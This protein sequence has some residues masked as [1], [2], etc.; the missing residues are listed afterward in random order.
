MPPNDR[1]I[2]GLDSQLEIVLQ[3]LKRCG[4]MT[5]LVVQEAAV[6][7]FSSRLGTEQKEALN[8]A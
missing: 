1:R 4:K 5:Q 2:W 8:D 6:A 3:V 7:D